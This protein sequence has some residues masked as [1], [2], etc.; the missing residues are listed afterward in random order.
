MRVLVTG[1]AGFLG[2]HLAERFLVDGHSVIG[3][4]SIVTGAVENVSLLEG[5]PGFTFVSGDV[6]SEVEV[7]GQLDGVLHFA[8]RAS[9]RDYLDAPVE[10]LETGS[11]GT[12]NA[13]ALADRKGAR[14]L[15]ASTSEV[16]GDPTVHPQPE[17]YWG[18]VNPIGVRGCY[19]EAKRFAEALTMAWRRSE[20][21]DTRIARIFNM[22]GPRLRPHDGRVVSNFIFQALS[23]QPLTIFG[24]GSQTRSLCYVSDGVEGI[25][26]L[27]RSDYAGPVNIGNPA[28][29]T[30]REIATAVAELV[31]STA[32]VTALPLPDDDPKVRCPDISL[33][34][35]VLGWEPKVDLRKGLGRTI[36]H[37]RAQ[38]AAGYEGGARTGASTGGLAGW[39]P[40][41]R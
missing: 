20:G 8:S 7:D 1:A 30:V 21:L 17:G 32:G 25:Y 12:G 24:D 3:L 40:E 11:V 23:G 33:A 26:R 34:R 10:T 5:Y 31:G 6:R 38:I 35:R 2:S 29:M 39:E 41:R 15:L 28:E 37:F 9:P 16:Y 18:S 36:S 4:D 19:D 27:F 14:F 13:L 22:Y